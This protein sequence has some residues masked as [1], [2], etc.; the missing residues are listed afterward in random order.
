RQLQSA[1]RGFKLESFS[2][3]GDVVFSY[4]DQHTTV[5]SVYN[6]SHTHLVVSMVV[7]TTTSLENVLHICEF[8]MYGD[9]L[10]PTGQYGRECEHKCN[11]LESDHCLVSTGRCTAECAA[12]YKGND[13]N[14]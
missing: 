7:I 6:I 11:C 4:L 2:E 5:Q 14:T 13:C 8:E 3:A 9:S 12:G 1:M 10:C